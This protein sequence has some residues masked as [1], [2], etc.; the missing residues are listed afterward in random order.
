MRESIKRN[1][2]LLSVLNKIYNEKISFINLQYGNDL[3]E[4]DTV[5]RKLKINIL[6]L[7]KFLISITLM[8]Y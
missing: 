3:N 1:I 8:V 5:K 6:H 4:I 2:D 7:K